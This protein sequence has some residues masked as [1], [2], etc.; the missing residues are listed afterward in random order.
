MRIIKKNTETKNFFF[1]IILKD[2]TMWLEKNK[3]YK[4][5]KRNKKYLKFI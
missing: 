5:R 1:T 4:L 3:K 2:L